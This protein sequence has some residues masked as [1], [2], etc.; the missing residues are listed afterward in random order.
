MRKKIL[1]LYWHGLGDI[2]CLTPQLRELHRRGHSIDLI[3]R[4]EAITSHLLASCSYVNELIPLPYRTGGPAEGGHSG[5]KKL[6]ECQELCDGIRQNYDIVYD[7]GEKPDR[8]RGGKI[9]RNN[10]VCGLPSS[11]DLSLEVFIPQDIE[12]QAIEYINQHYP[13]GYIFKHTTVE[14]HQFHNFDASKWMENNLPD[15]PI[16]D[17]GLG[18]THEMIHENIN[19]SFVLARQARHRVLSSSVFVHACDAMSAEMDLVHYGRDNTHGWP[20]DKNII[21]VIHGVK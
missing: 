19:F 21:K 11:I 8:V 9:F 14:W 2:I 10:K 12:Q 5:R 16:I 7:F 1:L 6:Q 3:C 20:L 17:T 15:L 13:D 18:G 4:R